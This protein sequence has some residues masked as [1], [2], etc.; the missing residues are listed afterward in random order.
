M[1]TDDESGERTFM[2]K[3]K[4]V[5]ILDMLQFYRCEI[6]YVITLILFAQMYTQK[7]PLYQ[8]ISLI[9]SEDETNVGGVCHQNVTYQVR[10][11][12]GIICISWKF[13]IDFSLS[14]KK[15]KGKYNFKNEI[16]NFI[17]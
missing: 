5:F 15:N 4:P 11:Q 12:S 16:F 2:Q 3:I 7:Y 10:K 13:I 17:S 1:W 8:F 9:K 6:F 14:N